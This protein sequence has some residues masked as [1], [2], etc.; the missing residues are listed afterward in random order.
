MSERW[1]KPVI[2]VAVETEAGEYSHDGEGWRRAVNWTLKPE[3]YKRV[4]AG[5]VCVHCMEPQEKPFPE[6]CSLCGFPMAEKQSSLL[7]FEDR[8]SK[9]IGPSTSMSDELD[10]LDDTSER[11]RHKSGSS[12]WLPRG[13]R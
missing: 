7:S 10:R 4:E 11:N 9:H 8:G 6:V 3:D 5:Y 12:I 13:V 1:R 2:P